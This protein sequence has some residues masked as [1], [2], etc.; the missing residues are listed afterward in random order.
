MDTPTPTPTPTHCK[1]SCGG[2]LLQLVAVGASDYWML[3]HSGQPAAAANQRASMADHWFVERPDG[4]ALARD[5]E[6]P[7]DR[8]PT[9]VTQATGGKLQAV[10]F[11]RR[12]LPHSFDAQ[13]L[14]IRVGEGAGAASYTSAAAPLP[15]AEA[16][17]AVAAIATRRS[18]LA[19]V[20]GIRVARTRASAPAPDKPTFKDAAELQ[21][22]FD[23]RIELRAQPLAVARPREGCPTSGATL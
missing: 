10:Q 12:V 18:V 19:D 2:G 22:E 16:A 9:F 20:E 5:L 13:T 21:A 8:R 7:A 3:A 23:A 1:P 4:A 15:A 14:P 6:D 11:E 17:A